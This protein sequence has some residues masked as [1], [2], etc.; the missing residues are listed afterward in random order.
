MPPPF[1][2][3]GCGDGAPVGRDP[4]H[5]PR[6]LIVRPEPL[7]GGEFGGVDGRPAVTALASPQQRQRALAEIDGDRP[8]RRFAETV[9]EDCALLVLGGEAVVAGEPPPDEGASVRRDREVAGRG[10]GEEA[11]RLQFE[12]EEG[13]DLRCPPGT[14]KLPAG[15]ARPQTRAPSTEAAQQP[16]IVRFARPAHCSPP[17][18]TVPIASSRQSISVSKPGSSRR[19]S[20]R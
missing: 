3:A 19:S 14:R 4:R 5:Q 15:R 13:V 11:A 8:G 10:L 20:I 7:A 1:R 12:R 2:R 17:G 6:P 18:A 9:D 16:E